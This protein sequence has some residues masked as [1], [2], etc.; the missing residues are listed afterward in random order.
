MNKMTLDTLRLRNFKGVQSFT[1]QAGCVDASIFGDNGTGKSTINDAIQW[2][3][4]DKDS[5]G[6]SS[7]DLQPI[8]MTGSK[9]RPV[10]CEVESTFIN[11]SKV[12]FK[13]VR[14]EKWVTKR[15]SLNAEL[16]GTMTDYYIDDVPKKMGE[17]KAKVAEIATSEEVFRLLTSP[18]Y[19]N[20]QIDR[21]KRRQMLF[22][23]VPGVT[24]ES[25]IAADK[26]L[27][28]IPALLD[29]KTVDER[30]KSLSA[31][32]KKIKEEVD[33]IPARI[34]E[35]DRSRQELPSV[36]VDSI[37]DKIARDNDRLS[38]KVQEIADANAGAG[39]ASLRKQV[40]DIEAEI[41][42]MRRGFN[43]SRE[44]R[45][46]DIRKNLNAADDSKT[47]IERTLVGLRKINERIKED[48]ETVID[49]NKLLADQWLSVD[50]ET[51]S[52]IKCPNCNHSF[53]DGGDDALAE[54]NESKSR[55]LADIEDKGERNKAK[56]AEL[57]KQIKE[58]VTAI[59]ANE[60]SLQ[61]ASEIV[62]KIKEEIK[63][64]EN[65]GKFEE[66][67]EYK[68][69]ADKLAKAKAAANAAE[70]DATPAIEKLTAEKADIEGRI[71]EAKGQLKAIER[72]QEINSRISELRSQEKKLQQDYEQISGDIFLLEQF[73]RAKCS[74]VEESINGMF[75]I[76]TWKLFNTLINGGIEETCEAMY[77]GRPYSVIST[78]ER[79][80]VGL[81]IIS[82]FSQQY[83]FAPICIVDNRESVTEIPEMDCQLIH[84]YVSEPDKQLRVV[85]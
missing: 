63:V 4:F 81:D 39:S 72:N 35:Q 65:S 16:T 40:A 5:R 55:R 43:A 38:A 78:G 19:F 53:V 79:I 60:Q 49:A 50:K 6:Q 34:D 15:G 68:A 7:F 20:E 22:D 11:G 58:N 62:A 46:A 57:N 73:E 84:L 54:L 24:D 67:D 52:K 85:Q 45:I 14:K 51:V 12:T 61:S 83:N 44:D 17:Y 48:I 30:R 74:A 71:E 3:L 28:G 47:G 64:V 66:T 1:L 41:D 26:K 36:K 21:K 77:E 56:I 76:V 10:E 75:R 37:N 80:K 29:G 8:G 9:E 23:L 18:T 25:I 2:L 31:T 13:K 32:R 70:V 59:I 27:D 82:T 69:A 33:G 42:G